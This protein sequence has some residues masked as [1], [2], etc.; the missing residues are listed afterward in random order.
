M[1]ML[2]VK[3]NIIVLIF[4]VMLLI[5]GVQGI[6]YGL[7]S[8]PTVTPGET[9]T[10]IKVSFI[11]FLFAY[12]ENA[13]QIQLRRKSPQGDWIT[14]C[15]TI[16]L[17]TGPDNIFS[18]SHGNYVISAIFTDLEPGVTYE[19]R[20]RDT[21]LSECHDNPPAPFSWSAITE[22]TTHL[23]PPPRVEFADANLA[24]AIREALDLDTNGDHIELLKIPEAELGKL[25]RLVLTTNNISDLTP[26]AQLTQLTELDLSENNIS[27]LTLLAQ[28]TQLTTLIL[29]N[30]NI[31]DLTPLAQLTQL[32]ELDLGGFHGNNISDLTPLTQLTLLRELDLSNNNISD[33][34][35]L[36][37]LTQLTWLYLWFN[38]ISDV[39]PLAQLINLEFLFLSYNDISDFTPLAQL[40]QRT[41]IYAVE[42]FKEVFHPS[43]IELM[44]VSTTAAGADIEYL[45]FIPSGYS[46]I[47]VPLRVNAVDAVAKTIESIGDLYDAFGGANAVKLL[48]TLDSHTQEWF[49]YFGPPAKGT[50]ADRELTD[51]MGI[52]ADMNTP[53]SV[54]LTGSPL[55]TNGNSIITLNPGYN[56]VGVPLNDSRL[57]YVSDLFTLEGIGGNAPVVIFTDNGDFKGVVPGG[58]PGDI[59]IIGGQAFILDAQRAAMVIIYGDGWT[60]IK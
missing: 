52:L 28:L 37:Q 26:L 43:D 55:G 14:K 4:T 9:N 49:V 19:A 27:D 32:T 11:D 12:D 46:L 42:L 8:A 34:T 1:K 40:P 16:S 33:V 39:T 24:T 50:P 13:Y 44:T 21:N 15:S 23:V 45:W 10:S 53:V 58:G 30:N 47:H 51:D 56:L 5:N 29:A 38:N 3:R 22:E 25:T 31:S 57:T 36:A 54:R 7:D 41:S 48:L 35:P 18:L 2:S 60:D 6:S 59:P 17:L 20:H